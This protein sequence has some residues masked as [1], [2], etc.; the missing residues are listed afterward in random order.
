M[1]PVWIEPQPARFFFGPWSGINRAHI[2]DYFFV[3]FSVKTASAFRGST[4]TSRPLRITGNAPSATSLQPL[5]SEQRRTFSANSGK[6][7]NAEVSVSNLRVLYK[8]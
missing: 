6:V 1:V 7:I 2:H 3:N 8:S 5:A 4:R